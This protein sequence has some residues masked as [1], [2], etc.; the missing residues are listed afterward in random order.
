MS[1]DRKTMVIMSSNGKGR[2]ESNKVARRHGSIS[3]LSHFLL[4]PNHID[5]YK[6][7]KASHS[8]KQELA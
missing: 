4:T 7:A 1:L 5:D 3:Y 2:K 6:K 8:R